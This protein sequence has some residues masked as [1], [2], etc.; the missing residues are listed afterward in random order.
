MKKILVSFAALLFAGVMGLSARPYLSPTSPYQYGHRWFFS[1]QGGPKIGLYDHIGS[2]FDYGHGWDAITYHG[3]LSLGYNFN[4]AW[5]MRVSG[6]YSYNAGACTPYEGIFYGYNYSAAYAF[7]DGIFDWHAIS[8]D[9]RPFAPKFYAGLGGA[10]T[11][12]F[13]DPEHPFE[14]L[15]TNNFV[16]A[17]RFGVIL[18]YDFPTGFGLFADIAVESFL[19]WYDGYATS[20]AIALDSALKVSFGMVWHFKNPRIRTLY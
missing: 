5:A 15:N 7:A 16:P 4:D 13:T 12:G 1:V 11:F 3:S 2:F 19:D 8:E 17:F 9:I 14:M 18:E 20:T 6:G 10:Y